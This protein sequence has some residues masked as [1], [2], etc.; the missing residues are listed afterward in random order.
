MKHNRILFLF[1]IAIL[2]S[3]LCACSNEAAKSNIEDGFDYE[4]SN[5]K[6][7]SFAFHCSSPNATVYEKTVND[8]ISEWNDNVA[9]AEKTYNRDDVLILTEGYIQ[10]INKGSRDSYYM[11]LS[12]DEESGLFSTEEL[13]VYFNDETLDSLMELKKGDY[14]TLLCTAQDTTFF[15]EYPE[16][17][18]NLILE[19]L[20]MNNTSKGLS[21]I[22][23][24]TVTDVIS[25]YGGDY[26]VECWEG[27]MTFYYEDCP[28]IFYYSTVDY[29]SDWQP[30][31]DDTIFGVETF[32]EGTTVYRKIKIGCSLDIVETFLGFKLKFDE[33]MVI[34]GEKIIDI[35][36]DGFKYT[37][38]FDEDSD[39][40]VS[41]S[42]WTDFVPPEYPDIVP[43]NLDLLT[44]NSYGNID[45]TKT[46]F[47][48]CVIQDDIRAYHLGLESAYDWN[49]DFSASDFNWDNYWM[50]LMDDLNNYLDGKQ[51]EYKDAWKMGENA[52]YAFASGMPQSNEMISVA[53]TI[54]NINLS[55]GD[56]R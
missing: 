25:Q 53:N 6:G 3:L 15:L 35:Y 38:R 13:R 39:V 37:L 55:L 28:Y 44:F 2:L 30:N 9:L 17:E 29:D 26:E 56:L 23:G 8:L 46:A 50:N 11:L 36:L 27:G 45:Y 41:A 1:Q 19:P 49:I 48:L 43:E 5:A 22:I 24:L 52:F 16:L 32:S 33:D 47:I 21:S 31:L 40:L 51:S 7:Q 20:E 42:C 12:Q 54:N 4:Y 10:N 18:V 34:G 14:V